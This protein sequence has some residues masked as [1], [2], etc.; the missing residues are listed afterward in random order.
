TT[1]TIYTLPLHDALP[2]WILVAI[3]DRRVLR[4]ER[5]LRPPR[6]ATL[7]GDDDHAVGRVGAVEGRSRR[8]AHDLDRLDLVRVDVVDPRRR[9]D[10]KST[11]LN[12]SHVNISY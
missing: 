8:A 10:R 4:V 12:S 1:P 6:D 5:P 9:R 3:G 2:I 11:R 7:G